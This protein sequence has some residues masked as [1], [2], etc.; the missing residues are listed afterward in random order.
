MKL[1]R[2]LDRL[3]C[4][5]PFLKGH[6]GTLLKLKERSRQILE[7]KGRIAQIH[8]PPLAILP[9]WRYRARRL[10]K[11][12]G[13]DSAEGLLMADVDKLAERLQLS[14]S[15]V[16]QWQDDVRNWLTVAHNRR[17]SWHRLRE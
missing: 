9:G 6:I 3:E 4:R 13:I 14:S 17:Q 2:V 12:T 5:P 1:Y 7:E 10:R 11:K 15:I 8:A 16:G